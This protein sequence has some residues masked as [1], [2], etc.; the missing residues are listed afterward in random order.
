AGQIRTRQ[1]RLAQVR[2]FK[3]SSAQNRSAQ[4]NALQISAGKIG[5][6]QVRARSAFFPTEEQRVRLNNVHQPLAVV[7]DAF[8]FSQ[9]HGVLSTP[10]SN[11]SF[12]PLRA[13]LTSASPI[14]LR[15]SDAP[16]ELRRPP[17]FVIAF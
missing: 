14:L 6:S 8:R 3:I 7:F 11:I 1:L 17:P 13:T 10:S 16:Q 15:A 9:S 2:S 4:I 5:A 12:Y